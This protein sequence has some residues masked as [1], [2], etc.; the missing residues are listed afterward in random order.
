MLFHCLSLRFRRISSGLRGTLWTSRELQLRSW[1]KQLEMLNRHLNERVVKQHNNTH[2]I[3]M[4]GGRRRGA[5]HLE[6]AV[7]ALGGLRPLVL[8]GKRSHTRNQHLRNHR[9]LSVAFSNGTSLLRFLVCNILPLVLGWAVLISSEEEQK[10]RLLS[11][12]RQQKEREQRVQHACGNGAVRCP[13]QPEQA[14]WRGHLP[15]T[16]VFIYIYTHTY[17]YTYGYIYIYIERERD[18]RIYIYIYIYI[19][20]RVYCAS[21]GQQQRGRE[22]GTSQHRLD[23]GEASGALAKGVSE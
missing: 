2:N 18:T 8:T 12:L 5:L 19:Y 6:P 22:P 1:G 17:T 14:A 11:S 21:R 10:G 13:A 20:M 3:T 7:R 15:Y 16:Y 9:G 4:S 23:P